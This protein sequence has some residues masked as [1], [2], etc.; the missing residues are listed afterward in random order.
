MSPSE[1]RS[2]CCRDH[3]QEDTRCVVACSALKRSYREVLSGLRD[4][5]QHTPHIA[6][7]SPRS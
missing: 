4:G 5:A 3:V 6:F 1:A 2:G 7:V